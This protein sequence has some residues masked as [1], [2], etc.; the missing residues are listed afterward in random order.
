MILVFS[1]VGRSGFRDLAAVDEIEDGV[2]ELVEDDDDLVGGCGDGR[3]A[4]RDGGEQ[5]GYGVGKDR[6]RVVDTGRGGAGSEM[7][8]KN[9]TSTACR[10]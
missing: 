5:Q 1:A 10:A 6:V 8:V 3:F 2:L 7:A 4:G 9:P